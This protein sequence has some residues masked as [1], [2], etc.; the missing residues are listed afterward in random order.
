VE[1]PTRNGQSLSESGRTQI[2]LTDAVLVAVQQMQQTLRPLRSQLVDGVPT[3]AQ[4]ISKA[5][6]WA[7][8]KGSNL[9][10]L[11]FYI[12]GFRETANAG[13]HREA[14]RASHPSPASSALPLWFDRWRYWTA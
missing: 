9:W 2:E 12:E 8:P 5:T 4:G 1:D 14:H 7:R 3:R 10:K 11:A 13:R 6:A